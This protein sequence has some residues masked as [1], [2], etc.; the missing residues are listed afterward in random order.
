M[1]DQN[2]HKAGFTSSGIARGSLAS[3]IMSGEAKS[4]GG[5]VPSGGTTATLQEMGMRNFQWVAK[6]EGGEQKETSVQEQVLQ[7][8][9]P[10]QTDSFDIF[11]PSLLSLYLT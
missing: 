1:S 5:G 7:T 9:H 11:F 10:L 4:F 8:V 2:V 3:S 6:E